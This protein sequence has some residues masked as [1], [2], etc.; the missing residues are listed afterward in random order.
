MVKE[1]DQGVGL[2][3]TTTLEVK[4]TRGCWLTRWQSKPNK[5][6]VITLYIWDI[7]RL[8]C[9]CGVVCVLTNGL[10]RNDRLAQSDWGT[11]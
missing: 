7:V 11:S 3:L 1:G 5:L 6:L 2:R 10:Y 8:L 4:F 9:W